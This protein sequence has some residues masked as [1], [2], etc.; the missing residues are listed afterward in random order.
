MI[1]DA[2]ILLSVINTYLRNNNGSLDDF[3][4]ENNVAVSEII[5]ALNSI[6]YHYDNQLNKFILK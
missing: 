3:A 6:G 4:Y 2:N 5:N 1:K